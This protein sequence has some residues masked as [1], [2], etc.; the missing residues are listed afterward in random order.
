MWSA[1][2]LPVNCCLHVAPAKRSWRDDAKRLHHLVSGVF[3]N[4]HMMLHY[5]GTMQARAKGAQHMNTKK[6][7]ETS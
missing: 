7:K 6:Y 5:P 2:S 3:E 1:Q 4:D